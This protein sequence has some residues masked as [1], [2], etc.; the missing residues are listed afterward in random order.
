MKRFLIPILVLMVFKAGFS[1]NPQVSEISGRGVGLDIVKRDIE[2][3][4]GQVKLKS[5][6]GRGTLFQI[7]LPLSL[8]ILEVELIEVA[9]KVLGVPSE[10]LRHSQLVSRAAENHL[11]QFR[12]GNQSLATH[13]LAPI[14]G[15]APY[16]AGEPPRPLSTSAAVLVLEVGADLAALVVD[17]IIGTETIFLKSLGDYLGKIPL[18][19]GAAVRASGEILVVLD[20]RGILDEVKKMIG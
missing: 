8:S 16:G 3:L 13:L 19:R 5:Q 15:F 10:N 18:V 2:H 9:G 17:R 20:G 7:I 6:K 1:Q 4:S 11:G 14:L 12:F